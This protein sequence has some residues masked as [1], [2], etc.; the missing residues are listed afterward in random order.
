MK[1]TLLI[2]IILLLFN[3]INLQ[4]INQAK[5]F[6][7]DELNTCEKQSENSEQIQN[8]FL[9]KTNLSQSEIE[10]LLSQDFDSLSKN[11]RK[12]PNIKRITEDDVKHFKSKDLNK[13]ISLL[14]INNISEYSNELEEKNE[15]KK[16]VPPY[17]LIDIKGNNE[18]KIFL[19]FDKFFKTQYK[20]MF[21]YS[22]TIIIFFFV[23]IGMIIYYAMFLPTEANELTRTSRNNRPILENI[24][25]DGSVK[26][27]SEN[28]YILKE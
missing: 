28:E 17:E 14:E 4:N 15:N 8:T 16:S 20:E 11:R 9:L 21:E 3:N 12:N 22:Y 1:K 23:L 5:E 2:L 24:S 27:D 10:E 7:Q 25:N 13:T 19:S 26:T 18:T 6:S